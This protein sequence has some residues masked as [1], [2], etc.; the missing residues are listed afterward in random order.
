MWSQTNETQDRED[1]EIQ[2]HC[3]L[4][5]RITNRTVFVRDEGK[6]PAARGR[7]PRTQHIKPSN[8]T[9]TSTWGQ[10][11]LLILVDNRLI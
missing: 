11:S 2:S 9:N 7:N 4:L 8:Q 10:F 3:H 5:V 6:G 1:P